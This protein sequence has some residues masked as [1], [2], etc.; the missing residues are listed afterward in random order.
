MLVKGT[1]WNLA[2]RAASLRVPFVS[3]PISSRRHA[4]CESNGSSRLALD[5]DSAAKLKQPSGGTTCKNQND[6]FLH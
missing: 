4:T 3:K 5:P 2:S 1:P 6:W